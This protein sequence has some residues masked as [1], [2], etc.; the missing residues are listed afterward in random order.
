MRWLLYSALTL[1][2]V[3]DVATTEIAKRTVPGFYEVNPFMVL[4]AGQP[5][6]L[7]RMIAAKVVILGIIWWLVRW[8]EGSY[9]MLSMIGL[10]VVLYVAIVWNNIGVIG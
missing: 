6:D 7:W 2:Q 5:P 9:I 4:L 1:L 10:A 3:A 8:S